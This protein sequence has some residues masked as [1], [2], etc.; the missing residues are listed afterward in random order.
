MIG[1]FGEVSAR[2]S[3][4]LPVNDRLSTQVAAYW[5]DHYDLRAILEALRQVQPGW[6]DRRAH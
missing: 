2:G 3:V 5:L 1:A 4:D 6:A